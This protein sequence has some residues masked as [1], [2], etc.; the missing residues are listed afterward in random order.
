MNCANNTQL[1]KIIIF[2]VFMVVIFAVID[3]KKE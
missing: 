1:V 2:F 3:K